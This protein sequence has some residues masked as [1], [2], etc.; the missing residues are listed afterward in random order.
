MEGVVGNVSVDGRSVIA[1]SL[2]ALI[3]R[4][5]VVEENEELVLMEDEEEEEV[6]RVE[7]DEEVEVDV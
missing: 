7:E 1:I 2:L 4:L 5:E 6:E 3:I